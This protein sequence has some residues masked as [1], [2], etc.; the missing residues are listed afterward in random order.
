MGY[1]R[2]TVKGMLD[3]QKVNLWKTI[4]GAKLSDLNLEASILKTTI[5][6]YDNYFSF[7]LVD[8]PLLLLP[9]IFYKILHRFMLQVKRVKQIYGKGK[10]G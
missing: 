8:F 1:E 2:S 10:I 9:N 5:K 3:F 6:N 7:W 4:I